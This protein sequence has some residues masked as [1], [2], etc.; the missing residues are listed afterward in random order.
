MA[1]YYWDNDL[2]RSVNSIFDN[3]IQ[4]LNVARRRTTTPRGD[5]T[6]RTWSPLIDVH[7]SDKELTV[8][9]ELPGL[10][11]DQVNVDI[12]NNALVISGEVKQDEK[13]NEGNTHVQ[14]R[15]F[16]SFTR[17]ISLPRNSKVEETSAKFNH[18]ILEV[19]IPKGE[20]PSGKRITIQ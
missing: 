12:R 17:S 16:G 20:I 11:K 2:E 8:H 10:D 1:L 5:V 14:E 3:F 18:G 4:D 19:I 15:R 6:K 13:Y 9:A 7:E